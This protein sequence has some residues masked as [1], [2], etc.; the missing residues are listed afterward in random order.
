MRINIHRPS[1]LMAVDGVTRPVDVE[2][3]PPGVEVLEWDSVR[4]LGR[5]QYAEDVTE[6]VRDRD[7]AAE[8][9]E[10]TRLRLANLPPL[11]EPIY[12]EVTVQRQPKVF[13][14]FSPYLELYNQWDTYVP[15][16]PPPPTPE[17]LERVAEQEATLQE[18]IG[19][20]PV[21]DLKAMTRAQLRDWYEANITTN[22]Q[23]RRVVRWLF[24]YVIRRL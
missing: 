13:D 3:L 11:E 17:E 10:N 18:N 12:H 6:Q 21:A 22:A 24:L 9:A 5:L 8:Q 2:L 23:V 1:G 19:P 16:P 20:V 15:P 7:L 14:D 4:G